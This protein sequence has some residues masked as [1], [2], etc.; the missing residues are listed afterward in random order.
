MLLFYPFIASSC[1]CKH[2]RQFVSTSL[3]DDVAT[4]KRVSHKFAA[5]VTCTDFFTAQCRVSWRGACTAAY[6]PFAINATFVDVQPM[7]PACTTPYQAPPDSSST[8]QKCWSRWLS[9]SS[10]AEPEA[11]S[12]VR[13]CDGARENCSCAWVANKVLVELELRT[14]LSLRTYNSFEMLKYHERNNLDI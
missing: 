5:T 9:E 14:D 4:R 11:A 2:H 6:Y 1:Q 3:P 8:R 12:A 13:A 7:Y 10:R